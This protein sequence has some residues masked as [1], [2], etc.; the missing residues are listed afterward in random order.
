M[1]CRTSGIPRPCHERPTE[2]LS[3][4][5]NQNNAPHPSHSRPGTE[6]GL[7]RT[8]GTLVVF[9]FLIWYQLHGYIY[10]VK[11]N[12]CPFLHVLVLQFN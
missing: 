5:D 8:S 3:P 4:G 9:Y 11:I 6:R 12:P 7:K 2:P 1:S 10:L